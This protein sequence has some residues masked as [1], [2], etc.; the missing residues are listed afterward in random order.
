MSITTKVAATVLLATTVGSGVEVVAATEATATAAAP[1]AVHV[2]VNTEGARLK[3]RKLPT[4]NSGT[5]NRLPDGSVEVA[6]CY[7]FGSSVSGDTKWWLLRDYSWPA[8]PQRDAQA[9]ARRYRGWV[10]DAY[11]L[12]VVKSGGDW[13]LAP[14]KSHR[15]TPSEVT[16]N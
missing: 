15:C 2:Q 5:V 13:V 8:T 10:S 9:G 3:V 14:V 12:T 11:I 16:I 1:S 7:T 6:L 4:T